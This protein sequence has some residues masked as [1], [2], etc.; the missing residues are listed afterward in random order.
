MLSYKFVILT[1]IVGIQAETHPPFVPR[2]TGPPED[3]NNCRIDINTIFSEVVG[4]WGIKDSS[5]VGIGSM[6]TWVAFISTCRQYS[7]EPSAYK[8]IGQYIWDEKNADKPCIQEKPI[9]KIHKHPGCSKDPKTATF[10]DFAIFKLTRAFDIY[11]YDYPVATFPKEVFQMYQQLRRYDSRE[12]TGT[13]LVPHFKIPKDKRPTFD[14]TAFVETIPFKT[15][16]VNL[17]CEKEPSDSD[18][19]QMCTERFSRRMNLTMLCAH[20]IKVDD[21]EGGNSNELWYAGS[22]LVCNETTLGLAAQVK[23][24][25]DF[26]QPPMYDIYFVVT[27]L[28]CW[29]WLKVKQKEYTTSFEFIRYVGNLTERGFSIPGPV[30]DPPA[31]IPYYEYDQSPSSAAIVQM[32]YLNHLILQLLVPFIFDRS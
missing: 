9:S 8:A 21:I 3:L 11:N 6:I 4:V 31:T 29:T 14:W 24:R 22:P 12:H 18:F 1:I 10:F 17:I 19:T 23:R 25:K 26:K 20:N 7:T 5:Y 32:P 13:C 30:T 2:G 15:E 28:R 27:L 16:C